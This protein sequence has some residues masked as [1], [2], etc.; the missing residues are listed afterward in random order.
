[1]RS[2]R[3]ASSRTVVSPHCRRRKSRALL[4][5]VKTLVHDGQVLEETGFDLTP[6]FPPAQLHPSYV[7]PEGSE[8]VPYYVELVIREQKIRLYFVPGI[9]ESTRFE[10]RTRKEISVRCASLFR[11]GVSV[12]LASDSPR[13]P[14][15]LLTWVIYFF[16]NRAEDRL[17]PIKRLADMGPRREPSQEQSQRGVVVGRVGTLADRVGERQAGQ[18]LHGHAFHLVSESRSFN[19]TLTNRVDE[20]AILSMGPPPSGL[21]FLNSHLKL[22]IDRNKPKNIPARH[23]NPNS[24]LPRPAYVAPDNSQ[25]HHHHSNFPGGRKLQPWS[26]TDEDDS[27]NHLPSDSERT[28]STAETEDDDD[29][30]NELFVAAQTRQAEQSWSTAQQGTDAL[31]ALFFGGGGGGGGG[32]ANETDNGDLTLRHDPGVLHDSAPLAP[33]PP[34]YAFTLGHAPPPPSSEQAVGPPPLPVAAAAA[35]PPP[36]SSQLSTPNS[37]HSHSTLHATPPQVAYERQQSFVQPKPKQSQNQQ[38]RL[39]DLLTG[40]AATPPPPPHSQSQSQQAGPM[41]VAALEQQVNLARGA[42]GTLTLDT[43]SPLAQQLPLPAHLPVSASTSVYSSHQPSPAPYAQAPAP[44]FVSDLEDS[45]KQEKRDALLRALLS[46]AAKSPPKPPPQELEPHAQDARWFA[47][48]PLQHANPPPSSSVSSMHDSNSGGGGGSLLS[49]LNGSDRMSVAAAAPAYGHSPQHAM[50]LPYPGLPPSV[51]MSTGH[52]Y[53]SPQQYPPPSATAYDP[54]AQQQQR[55]APR[56]N[57][58]SGPPIVPMPPYPNPP[59]QYRPQQ[60]HHHRQQYVQ[61]PYSQPGMAPPSFSSQYLPGSGGPS[62]QQPPIPPHVPQSSYASSNNHPMMPQQPYATG[63]AQHGPLPPMP[64]P[65]PIVPSTGG[66]GGPAG[67]QQPQA[68][69]QPGHLLGLLNGR[70]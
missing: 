27:T 38:T 56:V 37:T 22:W 64:P 55:Q 32:A 2:S 14:L 10:T 4:T 1:M 68:R 50:S 31:Q 59:Q 8:R 40:S 34:L 16:A 60:Q 30:D 70:S 20:S 25:R 5:T 19:L 24:P 57:N 69:V 66:P 44:V 45:Q 58:M 6:Y 51:A 35:P 26:S 17:V 67:V 12:S 36:Q 65:V 53:P 61:P 62:S 29:D 7:E 48:P 39:L 23:S 18:V 54:H 11:C 3:G 15:G 21:P 47:S 63:P 13:I 42:L 33:P 52:S 46:V 49:I 41:T 9:K 43:P 28:E